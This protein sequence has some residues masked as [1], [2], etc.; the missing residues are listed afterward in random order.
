[1][2][3]DKSKET[4]D[5]TNFFREKLSSLVDKDFKGS[6]FLMV[7]SGTRCLYLLFKLLGGRTKG[8]QYRKGSE[9]EYFPK[10]RT[11]E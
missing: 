2:T 9:K 6:N 11:I 5:R 1:M 4:I 7:L 10:R 8:N 3:Q